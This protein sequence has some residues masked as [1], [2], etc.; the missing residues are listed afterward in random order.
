MKGNGHFRQPYD[1]SPFSVKVSLN[2]VFKK[3]SNGILP[4]LQ[5]IYSSIHCRGYSLLFYLNNPILFLPL[6]RFKPNILPSNT[7]F[8]IPSPLSTLSIHNFCLLIISSKSY[9]S[10][11]T[12]SS[13]SQFLLLYVHF[14][15]SNLLHTHISNAYSLLTFSFLSVHISAL[16]N[17]T[18][19][20]KLFTSLLHN[21]L[22]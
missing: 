1:T 6:P 8:N 16:C 3:S 11:P 14:T 19:Q 15:F 7:V 2:G 12:M 9:F 22:S 13:T 18:L 5:A 10:S 4:S 21:D 20:I 17:S